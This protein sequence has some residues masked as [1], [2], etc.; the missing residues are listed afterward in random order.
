M[1]IFIFGGTGDLAQ[2]KLL[3]ALYRHF[4]AERLGLQVKIYGIG[5]S[6]FDVSSY[7]QEIKRK[8]STNLES[9][10]Y[11]EKAIQKFIK[12]IS[13]IK[14]DFNINTDF[15]SLKKITSN[16]DRNIFYL[17]VSPIYYKVIAENLNKQ[18]L[19]GPHLQEV[20]RNL[21]RLQVFF[22]KLVLCV[23]VELV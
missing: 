8:L 19:I 16:K 3:P 20:F 22:Q 7:Q 17:A 21:K 4:K 6:S 5:S 14:I 13:Y 12:I 11:D 9:I 2:R 10:E 1:N 23:Q 15:D 18:T